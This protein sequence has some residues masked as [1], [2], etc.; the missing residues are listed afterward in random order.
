MKIL[1]RS[2]GKI[3]EK[4]FC[5]AVS[6]YYKR[7][8]KYTSLHIEEF[9]EGRSMADETDKLVSGLRDTDSIILLDRQGQQLSS[10]KFSALVKKEMNRN[11]IVF[12]IGGSN[13]VDRSRIRSNHIISFS[14]LTFPHQMFR[15]ILLEQIYRAFK[16]MRNE[17]Y[18]K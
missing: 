6:D 17:P 14:E 2:I 10:E 18:H 8:R 4:Y 1:I 13:G 5:D 15:V 12:L 9:K 11:R 3:K 7:I 16:I